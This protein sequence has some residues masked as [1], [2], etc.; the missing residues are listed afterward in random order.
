MGSGMQGKSTCNWCHGSGE[1]NDEDR[2][3]GHKNGGG[4][5]IF[6]F[7]LIGLSILFLLIF[8][9]VALPDIIKSL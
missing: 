6:Q 2:D 7:F 5:N 9:F 3:A 4:L 1:E 8:I